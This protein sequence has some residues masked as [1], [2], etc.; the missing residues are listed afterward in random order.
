MPDP[1][2]QLIDAIDALIVRAQAK[3]PLRAEV[4]ES[5][6]RDLRR[7]AFDGHR[8]LDDARREAQKLSHLYVI[9][10]SLFSDLKPAKVWQALG[11]IVCNVVGSEDFCLYERKD[12]AFLPVGGMGPAFAEAAPFDYQKG[13]LGLAASAAAPT[14][15]EPGWLAV[16]A[17]VNPNG[18]VVGLVAIRRLLSHKPRLTF[19]DRE[20]LAVLRE[21][22]GTALWRAL[23]A[24]RGSR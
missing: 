9:H 14:Y 7:L 2:T 18:A 19:E 6:L 21:E 15:S 24:E 10:A 16:T 5:L 13:P 22:A 11:E 3:E 1:K 23:G 17:L 20:V 12:R 4:L 8:A